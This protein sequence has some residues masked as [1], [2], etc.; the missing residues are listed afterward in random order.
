MKKVQVGKTYVG[1]VEDNQDPKKEGRVKVRVMD[2]FDDLKIEDVPWATPWKDLNGN[3]SNIPDKGKVVITVFDQGDV[4]KPE[5]IFSDHYNINLENKLKSLSDS[6]YLS[7]KSLLFD[8]K[9]QI[10]VNDSEGLKIDHKYNNINIKENSVNINLKDNNMMVNIGDETANQQML[11]GNHWLDWFDEFVDILMGTA[12]IAGGAPAMPSPPLIRSLLKYKALKNPKFLSHHV[13]VVDNDKVSNVKSDKREESAQLGDG[14]TSTKAENTVTTVTSEKHEPQDGPKPAY[15]DKYVAPSTEVPGT[16]DTK[17]SS[18]V[19]PPSPD[20]SIPQSNKKVEDLIRF[21][22][23]KSYKIFEENEVMNIVALRKK[24][25]KPTNLFDDELNIFFKNSKGNWDLMEYSITTV[26]GYKPGTETLPE[27]VAILRLGQYVDQ[28]KMGYHKEDEKHKCLKFDKCAIHRNDNINTYN[29]ESATEI[30][31]FSINIHRSSDLST[32]EYVFNY[33][34][35]SQV[36]KNVNQYNQFI[37]LCENQENNANKLLFT[38]TLCSKKEFEDFIPIINA[39]GTLNVERKSLEDEMKE[40]ANAEMESAKGSS[41]DLAAKL[42]PVKVKTIVDKL[43]DLEFKSEPGKPSISTFQSNNVGATSSLPVFDDSDNLSSK[44]ISF[45]EGLTELDINNIMRSNPGMGIRDAITKIVFPKLRKELMTHIK[46]LIEKGKLKKSDY[47][48]LD[49]KVV[50][51]KLLYTSG[52]EKGLVVWRTSVIDTNPKNNIP[53]L[54][55]LKQSDFK[56]LLGKYTNIFDIPTKKIVPTRPSPNN[57][58][59]IENESSSKVIFFVEV[60]FIPYIFNAELL[61]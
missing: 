57:S 24:D 40:K 16:P 56:I 29:Y 37:K 8:H 25:T 46:Y 55:E 13:N 9:T 53:S 27:N 39:D 28:L 20:L 14:W 38:Y 15:D 21:L 31:N 32:S 52:E 45:G 58:W 17:T 35:G 30:G 1:V 47:F 2:V 50:E 22:K 48:G 59:V 51:G 33:S 10:Y 18:T 5:F 36:F 34:E 60:K 23:S 41:A 54:H 42:P 49:N 12:F 19:L 26:P 6:D 44:I 4:Y 43:K 11:L 61:F 3:G 7:M